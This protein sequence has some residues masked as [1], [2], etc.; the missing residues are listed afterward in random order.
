MRWR[1]RDLLHTYEMLDVLL[2]I[3]MVCVLRALLKT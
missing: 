2:M 1:F 3:E